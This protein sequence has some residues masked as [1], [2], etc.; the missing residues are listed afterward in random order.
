MQIC[1]LKMILWSSK[2]SRVV[3]PR[4][5]SHQQTPAPKITSKADGTR[6]YSYK[7]KQAVDL[8]P[9][10]QYSI[11]QKVYKI[12]YR[13]RKRTNL[14]KLSNKFRFSTI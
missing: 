6:S 3:D 1:S 10:I 13:V 7:V 12:Q 8:I 4:Y 9:G 11:I 5:R 14:L 2:W